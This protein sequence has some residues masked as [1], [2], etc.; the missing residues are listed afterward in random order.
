MIIIKCRSLR[1]ACRYIVSGIIAIIV[2][3]IVQVKQGSWIRWYLVHGSGLFF[4]K[5][6][7]KNGCCACMH[8]RNANEC[9]SP[10]NACV[11][12]LD[13][14]VEVALAQAQDSPVINGIHLQAETK[15]ARP[16]PRHIS[17]PEWRVGLCVCVC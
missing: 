3:G 2:S 12:L 5:R 14:W 9:Q 13:V 11:Q 7:A 10:M 16:D 17:T 8:V 15:A 6:R 4:V 1:K